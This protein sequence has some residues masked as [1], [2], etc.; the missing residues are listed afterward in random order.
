ML[1]NDKYKVKR[2][3]RDDIGPE[4]IF[5][6]SERLRESP[7]GEREKLEKPIQERV[8]KLFFGIVILLLFV[9]LV[10]S[11]HLQIVKGGYW[12][13]LANEN[14]IRS[15]PIRPLR[16]I[17]YDKN[18]NPLAINIPKIDI[19]VIPADF[20]QE[21]NYEQV[22]K[23]L[24]AQL[25]KPEEEIMDIIKSH[26]NISYPIIISEDIETEKAL[27]IESEFINFP[28]IR[29][30]KDNRRQYEDGPA[31]AHV[32]GYVDKANENEVKDKK[33]LLD[34][35]IG[36]TGLE[37]IYENILRGT[38]GQELVE[39]DSLGRTQ[40]A[41]A[42]KEPVFGNDLVLS[43]DADLQKKIY[44]LLKSKLNNINASKAAVVAINPQNGKIL[45]MVS[46]PSFDSND[47]IKGLTQETFNKIFNNKNEPLFNR[48]VS[49]TYPPGST[50]KPLLASAAL[51][52]G[53]I[54]P[55]TQINCPGYLNVMD[56]YNS[57]VVWTYGDWKAHGTVDI[58][59]A[60]AESCNVFFYT[61]GGGYGNIEGLGIERIKKYL[62]LFNLGKTLGINLP[63]EKSGFIPS[64][65]WKT[66]EKKEQW[67]IGD[68]Y[69]C[70]IGQGDIAVTPLQMAIAIATIANGGTIYKPKL[71][72]NDKPEI[73]NK[74]FINKDFIEVV[75]KGMREVIVSGSAR[76]LMDLPIEVAGKTGTAESLKGKAPHSWFT[77]FAPYNN[78][79]I[80]LTILIE[81]GGEGSTTAVPIAKDILGWYFNK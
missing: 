21:Q 17:I 53:V 22:I 20:I 42:T 68:T 31:F 41:L 57:N 76:S 13:N 44:Q 77:V 61:V 12:Q 7:E 15:Y 62:N 43:I 6:D 26:I 74:N 60:I 28:S 19:A 3:Y 75:K 30:I 5:L 14:K 50:I 39:I 65:E 34:D 54:T 11:F 16:G 81:N 64:P 8:L 38:Y 72:E 51:Q 25:S 35:Y 79:E 71:L 33:Y 2:K 70:S 37:S 59:K 32:L 24:S 49:G 63:E 78:P 1:E 10:K 18:K 40:K 48:A 69:N 46:L 66:K 27:V 23:N 56:K 47:F 52:E 73:I 58:Y 67:Y 4:E 9:L 29:V 36:R 55:K 80:V 45:A